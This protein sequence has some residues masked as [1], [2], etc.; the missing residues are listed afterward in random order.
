M[1]LLAGLDSGVYHTDYGYVVWFNTLKMLRT[2]GGKI[3]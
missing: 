3:L 1:A 2:C